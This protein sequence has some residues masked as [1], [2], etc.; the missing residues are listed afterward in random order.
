MRSTSLIAILVLLCLYLVPASASAAVCGTPDP[1]GT[2]KLKGTLTLDD[3]ASTLR[4]DFHRGGGSRTL[5]LVFKVA[6]CDLLS[7]PDVS[8]GPL[9]DVDQEI[10]AD[11][12]GKPT[13]K[14]Q[15]D[16]LKIKYTAESSELDPGT[17]GSLIE[18]RDSRRITT[19]RA[20]VTLSRSEPS[21]LV[22]GIIGLVAGGVGFAVFLI[23]KTLAGYSL[24]IE[25]PKIWTLAVVFACGAGAL[26]AI[27]NWF[28]QDVWVWQEN[29]AVAAGIAFTQS[30]AGV[31]VAV[32]A[33]VFEAE[34]K[35]VDDGGKPRF[36]GPAADRPRFWHD[37]FDA[38]PPAFIKHVEL[39]E[40]HLPTGESS[41]IAENEAFIAIQGKSA[42]G[43]WGNEERSLIKR[44]HVR[45]DELA[46]KGP[47]SRQIESSDTY[48]MNAHRQ[49][50]TIKRTVEYGGKTYIAGW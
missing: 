20:P 28:D 8:T 18:V 31:V 23:T 7:R 14:A 33:G 32:T 34:P 12:I 37:A 45:G 15:G 10:P 26:A 49:I 44:D 19:A 39:G 16:Q 35:R 38:F 17:Y 1:E 2:G 29:G 30:T 11:A 47:L 9:E 48:G 13:V 25:D 40:D 46:V 36:T 5:H 22:P 21:A 41:H 42:P 50:L 4:R 24:A 6:N 43:N 27:L 3:E